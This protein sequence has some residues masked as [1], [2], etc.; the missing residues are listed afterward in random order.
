MGV[1]SRCHLNEE[2]LNS[3]DITMHR[4]ATTKKGHHFY[5]VQVSTGEKVLTAGVREG[6]LVLCGTERNGTEPVKRPPT[7]KQFF[8]K[9]HYF[10][11]T[12]C[13]WEII[14]QILMFKCTVYYMKYATHCFISHYTL[15]SRENLKSLVV[16]R[17]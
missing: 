2:L 10:N 16:L 6:L 12:Y 15:L 13:K 3:S 7:G 9:R 11:Y 14:F 4:D 8:L 1:L 17:C 5:A